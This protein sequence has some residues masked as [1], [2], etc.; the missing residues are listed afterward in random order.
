[1]AKNIT[2][3]A[4]G[5]TDH[6]PAEQPVENKLDT[7]Y[8][9]LV[10]GI[11]VDLLKMQRTAALAEAFTVIG[12]LRGRMHAIDRDLSKNKKAQH[13][14]DIERSLIIVGLEGERNA[15]EQVITQLISRHFPFGTSFN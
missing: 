2:I 1:M 9:S 14:N 7:Q 6:T 8:L 5:K 13:R 4:T 12:D 10:K 3:K 15:L 11:N